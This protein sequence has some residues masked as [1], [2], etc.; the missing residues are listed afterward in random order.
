MRCSVAHRRGERACDRHVKVWRAPR[1]GEGAQVAAR[2]CGG[3]YSRACGLEREELREEPEE[4][5]HGPLVHMDNRGG[6][7]PPNYYIQLCIILP[8]TQAI[9]ASYITRNPQNPPTVLVR[10]YILKFTPYCTAV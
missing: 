5:L 8:P 1:E 3:D 2:E 4:G 7:V 9:A 10:Y 6:R